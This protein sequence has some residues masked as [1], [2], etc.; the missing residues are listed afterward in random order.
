[1]NKQT[2][3][4]Y[5]LA[6]ATLALSAQAA[7]NSAARL[8]EF[9][10]MQDWHGMWELDGSPVTLQ[11]QP[12]PADGR[13]AGVPT[14]V[15]GV[16]LRNYPPYNAEWEAKY[17]KTLGTDLMTVA[18]H[19]T[20]TRYCA[21]GMPRVL[22]SPFM[23]EAIVTPEKV[24]FIHAQREIR[25]VYTD[26]RKHPEEDYQVATLWGDSIGHW[27]GDALLIDTI[28]ILPELYLDPSGGTL[29]GQARVMERWRMTGPDALQNEITIVDPV[30]FRPG[31]QWKFTREYKRVKD[32]DRMIDDVCGENDRNP[33]VNGVIQ[34]IVK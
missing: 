19:N 3:W 34:T 18:A 28:S 13:R 23:F 26:G 32:F 30:A 22:A 29:S 27:E 25:H 33:I 12:S 10:R 4:A 6:I 16:R 9:A 31:A 1:M 21:A 5:A 24:W 15:G 20:N 11:P 14:A 17:Q 7:S 2:K 8:R